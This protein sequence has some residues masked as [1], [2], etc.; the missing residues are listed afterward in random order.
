MCVENIIQIP[1]FQMVLGLVSGFLFVW[2][3]FGILGGFYVF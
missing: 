2:F 1:G 3:F